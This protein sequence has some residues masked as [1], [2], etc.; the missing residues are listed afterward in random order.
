MVETAAHAVAR[1]P[2]GRAWRQ[3]FG[4]PDGRFMQIADVVYREIVRAFS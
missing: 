2:I 1:G 3:L 4:P